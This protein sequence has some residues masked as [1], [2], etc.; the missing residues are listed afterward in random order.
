MLKRPSLAYLV[1][2]LFP[3]SDLLSLCV[4]SADVECVGIIA[5]IVWFPLGIGLCLLD[6]SVNCKRCGAV[7]KA[8]PSIRV[9]GPRRRDGNRR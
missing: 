4:T 8:R 1:S 3:C 2:F 6:R 7:I 5:A 9:G